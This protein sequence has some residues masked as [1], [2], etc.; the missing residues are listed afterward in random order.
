MQ[1]GKQLLKPS[2][3][4]KQVLK[5]LGLY[6]LVVLLAMASMLFL[7]SCT[8]E[9]DIQVG[10]HVWKL[11]DKQPASRWMDDKEKDYVWLVWQTDHDDKPRYERVTKERAEQMLIGTTIINRDKK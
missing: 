3:M 4:E 11:V 7:T 2:H 6:V 10:V 5:M 1:E 9:K 8:F